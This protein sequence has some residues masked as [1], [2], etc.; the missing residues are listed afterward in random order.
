MSDE[1]TRTR[2]EPRKVTIREETENIEVKVVNNNSVK[3]VRQTDT[4]SKKVGKPKE[5]KKRKELA[6]KE[7]DVNDIYTSE[8]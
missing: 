5:D 6:M 8:S 7:G 1:E 3:E 4:K 2:G